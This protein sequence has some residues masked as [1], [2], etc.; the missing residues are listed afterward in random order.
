MRISGNRIISILSVA[1]LTLAAQS[2]GNSCAS[3][4]SNSESTWQE[5]LRCTKVLQVEATSRFFNADAL[6][7]ELLKSK[8]FQGL[9]YQ[10]VKHAASQ[11]ASG[12]KSRT[13]EML[14]RVTRKKFTTRFTVALLNPA[15]NRLYVSEESSSLGG[16]IEPDL[17]KS[18]LKWI[19]EANGID[20]AKRKAESKPA[21]S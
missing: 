18:I 9:G 5:E 20:P 12:A 3:T 14:L 21:R 19:R 10:A 8:D 1:G 16:D 11:P 17:A 4:P 15:S 13:G 6:V 7:R 2:P